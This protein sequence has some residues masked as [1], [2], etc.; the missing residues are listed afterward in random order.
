MGSQDYPPKAGI[1]EEKVLRLISENSSGSIAKKDAAETFNESDV[2][3]SHSATAVIGGSV[4]LGTWGATTSRPSDNESASD[5]RKSGLAINPNIS[6]T[7]VRA[8]VSG[9]TLGLTRGYLCQDDGTVIADAPI[10]GGS[11]AIADVPLSSGTRYH[12]V[13]DA[14][15]AGYTRGSYYQSSSPHTGVDV[16]II[17]G[18]YTASLASSGG[19]YTLNNVELLNPKTSGSVTVEWPALGDIYRW[20]AATF[21]RTPDGETVTVNIEENDGSGW[22][23]IAADISRGEDITAAPDSDVRFRVDIERAEPLNNPTLDSIYRRWVV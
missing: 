21:T 2:T 13:A 3:L 1:S 7:G 6:G 5:E 23:E 20:D 8:D 14:E 18:L 17:E 15:G 19:E 12:L 11:F 16:D 4:V 10:D 22:T 9:N